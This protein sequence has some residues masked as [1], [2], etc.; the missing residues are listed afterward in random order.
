MLASADAARAEMGVMPSPR[1]GGGPISL[2]MGEPPGLVPGGPGD[3]HDPHLCQNGR[4]PAARE[5]RSKSPQRTETIP[6][7]PPR[8]TEW[9]APSIR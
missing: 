6:E 3:R 1:S 4:R 5:W 9:R 8:P 2:L 7:A